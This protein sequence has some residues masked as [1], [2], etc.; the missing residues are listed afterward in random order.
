MRHILAAFLLLPLAAGS[1]LGK[2]PILPD[3]HLTPGAVKTRDIGRICARGY[4]KTVRHTSARLKRQ[5]Y[6]QYGINRRG[7]HYE[8]DHLIPLELGGA[9]VA[10]NLWP[11][12]YDTRP[13]NARVKDQLENFFHAE[14]C[15]RRFDI[16][17][18]QREIA[19][20][21]IAAY[22]QYLGEPAVGSSRP[23]RR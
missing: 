7:G 22:R 8:I 19:A 20:N 14:V 3:P 6:R 18:A 23:R 5:I 15:A 1:A 11:Q 2:D 4:T 10:A 16:D 17:L 21:W 12:S 13:W 9:D